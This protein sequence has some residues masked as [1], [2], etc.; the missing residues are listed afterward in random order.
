MRPNIPQ[1]ISQNLS[2]GDICKYWLVTG[3]F[4]NSNMDEKYPASVNLFNPVHP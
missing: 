3:K 1:I 4:Y 2:K